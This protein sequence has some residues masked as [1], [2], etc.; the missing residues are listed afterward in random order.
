MGADNLNAVRAI[1]WVAL[2]SAGLA[3]CAKQAETAQQVMDECN[4]GG[5]R[6]N[7]SEA[8]ISIATPAYL[9][10]CMR[11]HSW[12]MSIKPPCAGDQRVV[13]G[14]MIDPPHWNDAEC[15]VKQP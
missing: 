5:A 3:G 13:D 9:V 14:A 10:A 2:A 4:L 7:P 11:S 1:I 6:A 12:Y 8:G 15:Y